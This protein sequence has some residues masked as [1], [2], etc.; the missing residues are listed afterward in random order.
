MSK[1]RA[2]YLLPSIP[3]GLPA[4]IKNGLAI[5]NA[6]ATEGRCPACGTV[7]QIHGPDRDG[8]MHLVFEH[9]DECGVLHDGDAAA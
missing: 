6:C 5:R 4:E 3:D 9:E 2:L 8:F 1:P 7:G